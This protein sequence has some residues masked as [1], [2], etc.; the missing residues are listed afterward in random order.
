MQV[1]KNI[2]IVEDELILAM[3]NQQIVEN[4]GHTVVKTITTGEEA[5][6]FVK[7]NE[8][9]IILMDILLEGEKDGIMA[10][11]EIRLFSD[12]PVIYITGNSDNMAKSRADKT[13]PSDFL[14]KPVNA[15]VLTEVINS[16]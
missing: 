7:D 16:L 1:T 5:V 14:V 4:A 11:E 3:L 2:L 13:K 10:M 6:D 9:D 15:K 8:P 12:V